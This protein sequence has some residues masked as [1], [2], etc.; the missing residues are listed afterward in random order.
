MATALI[1][2]LLEFYYTRALLKTTTLPLKKEKKRP[3]RLE[4]GPPGYESH[5]PTLHH[6][7]TGLLS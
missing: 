3:E 5:T 4:P 2:I 7:T 6:F 1:H